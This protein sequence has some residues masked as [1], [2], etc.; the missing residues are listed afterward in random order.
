MFLMSRGQVANQKRNTR[1]FSTQIRGAQLNNIF[2]AAPV[3][4]TAAAPD[5]NI[6]LIMCAVFAP[7][8]VINFGSSRRETYRYDLGGYVGSCEP[9]SW[10][11][12]GHGDVPSEDGYATLA[13]IHVYTYDASARRSTRLIFEMLLRERSPSL[14]SCRM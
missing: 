13:G 1:A 12:V 8:R 7:G 14:S 3:D 6:A 11:V 9:S 10:N 2:D 4:D 5:R